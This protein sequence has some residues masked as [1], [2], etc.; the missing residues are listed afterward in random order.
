MRG[1]G[2]ALQ[3]PSVL[4]PGAGKPSS[5]LSP[6]RPLASKG[7]AANYTRSLGGNK[8]AELGPPVRATVAEWK[9]I[10]LCWKHTEMDRSP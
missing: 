7:C 6:W 9:W 3:L 1:P 2:P 8:K 5:V 10:L 4:G